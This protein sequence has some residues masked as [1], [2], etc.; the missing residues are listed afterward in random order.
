MSELNRELEEVARNG[1]DADRQVL[2]KEQEILAKEKQMEDE[3]EEIS[4]LKVL[5]E[6][7]TKERDACTNCIKDFLQNMKNLQKR[8]VHWI[9]NVSVCITR[10]K[11]LP[12]VLT[13]G[14][15]ICGSSMN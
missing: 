11:R 8:R 4:K 12:S 3:R 2:Q 13:A 7:V 10:Q 1:E 15:T 6:E 5:I 14:Q 9:A